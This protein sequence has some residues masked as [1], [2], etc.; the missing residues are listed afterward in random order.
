MLGVMIQGAMRKATVSVKRGTSGRVWGG[1]NE[2]YMGPAGSPIR[3]QDCYSP[4]A[5][6]APEIP[7]GFP[8]TLGRHASPQHCTYPC[9]HQADTKGDQPQEISVREGES[10]HKEADFPLSLLPLNFVG[11]ALRSQHLLVVLEGMPA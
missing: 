9:V 5:C 1:G 8:H 7:N 10:L 11:Q 6:P 3:P 4:P 2:D